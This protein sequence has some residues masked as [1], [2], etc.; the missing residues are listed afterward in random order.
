VIRHID[1]EGIDNFRDFGGYATASGR[2][3]KQGV[4]YRSGH[5]ARATDPDLKG[6]SGLGVTT[7]V[8][9]RNPRERV[10]EPSRRWR[11]F[12]SRVIENDTDDGAGDW[13]E[14]LKV[15]DID[16]RRFHDDGVRFYGEAPFNRRYLAL[17]R[18]YFQAL[19]EIDGPMIVHC[20]AG[21]D[22]TGIVCAF[23]HHIAGVPRDDMLADYLLTNDEDRIGRRIAHFGPWLRKHTGRPR[24]TTRRCAPR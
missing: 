22:R 19:A 17:F 2:G 15:G 9:L 23:T 6:L 18:H 5:H 3:L 20:T 4:L 16:A 21:K 8:D 11:G 12:A 24:W 10:R 14:G 13:A 7:I 1:F